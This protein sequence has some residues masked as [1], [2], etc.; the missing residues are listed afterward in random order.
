MVPENLAPDHRLAVRLAIV[1]SHPTQYYSPWFRWLAAHG[2]N[3]RVYYLWD[4]GV[5][6][7]PDREFGRTL[8]W[9]I[10]L[11]SGYEHEF[12]P[13]RASE[14]GTHHLR[15]LDNPELPGRLAAWRPD[16][17]LLF[18]YKYL[19]HLRLIF[20]GRYPLV[21][22]GDSHLLDN[23]KPSWL[24]RR[25]LG[26]VYRRFAAFTY[27]GQANLAY[28]RALGVPAEKLFHAPHTVDAQHFTATAERVAA[29]AALRT[30]LGLTRKRVLLF[31]GKLIA[32]KQPRELLTA[33]LD[34]SASDWA[35][36]FVGDGDQL[37]ELKQLAASRPDRA[38]R[39]LPF[40]NQSEMPVRYLL[41]DVFVLPS[42]GPEETW[43]LAV[44]EAMH[45]GVPCLVSDRVGCQ[46]DLVSEGETGWVFPAAE[47]G[48]LRATLARAVS[49][50][51]GTH[52]RLREQVTARIS[53]YT[54]AA[55]S[56]GLQA[57]VSAALARR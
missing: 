25:L 57:A 36:L 1:I 21:F 14:P 48:A 42:R 7:R 39:F 26:A 15:G 38:V 40:A 33:F 35:L 23:T 22:R 18:G 32:K 45:L 51:A 5:T 16:A 19:T 54:Y 20:G 10:D 29:A 41:A 44:N 34:L 31:A 4:F 6:P 8:Q 12:V 11:L 28:F 2:W 49:A 30:E 52:T 46:Q 53:G 50:D 24:K 43:G 9:D 55:A 56:A 13:N 37:P 27:V 47:P 17:V 3:I